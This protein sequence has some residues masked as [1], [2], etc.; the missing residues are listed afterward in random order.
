MAIPALLLVIGILLIAKCLVKKFPKIKEKVE[1]LQK[2]IFFGMII[3]VIFTGFLSICVSSGMGKNLCITCDKEF[4]TNWP[5]IVYLLVVTLVVIYFVMFIEGMEFKN[6][7][8][9]TK[10]GVLYTE[11]VVKS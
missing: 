6:S 11:L 3:T 4:T 9:K 10:F 2:M 7:K 8:F 5:Q 1:A